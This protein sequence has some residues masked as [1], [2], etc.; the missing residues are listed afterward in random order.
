MLLLLLL[1]K[2]YQGVWARNHAE[3][4]LDAVTPTVVVVDAL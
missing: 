1:F 2:L 3:V 4:V